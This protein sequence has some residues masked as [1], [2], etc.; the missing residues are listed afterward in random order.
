MTEKQF[1]SWIILDVNDLV[2]YSTNGRMPYSFNA[3]FMFFWVFVQ[4]AIP[5]QNEECTYS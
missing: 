2:I 3:L 1:N 5:Q 4:C